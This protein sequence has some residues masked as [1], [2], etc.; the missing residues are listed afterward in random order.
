MKHIAVIGG[1]A[2]GLSAAIAAAECGAQVTVLERLPRVGKKILLTGNGRC[3]LGTRDYAPEQF[4]ARFHGSFPAARNLLAEFDADAYFRRFGLLTRTDSAGRMY[5]YSNTAASVLDALRFAAEQRGVEFRCGMQVTDLRRKGDVWQIICGNTSVSADAVIAA[6]G[7]S[8]APA[9]GTDGNLLPV[10]QK[11]GHSIVPALPALCPVPTDA[12][13]VKP[14]AGMRVQ[15]AVTAM[16]HG[17]AL[18]TERGEVQFTAGAL[19]GIC[20]FNLSR[21]AAIHG[22]D[23]E[24]S[25][26][27]LPDLDAA[28]A[29]DYLRML[30]QQRGRLAGNELLTGVLPRRVGETLLKQI[31]GKISGEAHTLLRAGADIQRLCTLLKDWRFPVAGT[32]AFTQ[33]QVTAGGV[34]GRSLRNDLSSRIVPELY[35]CGELIDIDGD[36]GGYNLMWAWCSG[37]FAGRRACGCNSAQL[38]SR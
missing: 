25:L 34:S 12:A 32:A 13:R 21:L 37:D 16:L 10:L 8:A 36:C 29:A 20:V 6:A 17:K 5:P 22:S 26:D 14:L 9:C 38:R 27:L 24:L 19:S 30:M 31:C 4:A 23:M 3:N 28:Q 35:F 18:K 11:L 7:G 1:G 15:A 2:S 33:A